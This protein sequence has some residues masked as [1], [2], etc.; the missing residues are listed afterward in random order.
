V[1]ILSLVGAKGVFG[2]EVGELG[3]VLL[4]KLLR[5]QNFEQYIVSCLLYSPETKTCFLT[6]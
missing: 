1:A 3:Q 5:N 4:I 6:N 2:S